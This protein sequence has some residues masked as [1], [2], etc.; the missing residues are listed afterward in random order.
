MGRG[1]TRPYQ[2]G[3][4]GQSALSFITVAAFT[5]TKAVDFV[6]H[7]ATPLQWSAEKPQLHTAS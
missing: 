7:V 2:T 1:G 6:M 4:W 3:T 5:G